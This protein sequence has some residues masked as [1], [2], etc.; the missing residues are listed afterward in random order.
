SIYT[1]ALC[2]G[3]T[4]EHRWRRALFILA[5]IGTLTFNWT[6]GAITFNLISIAIP[7]VSINYGGIYVPYSLILHFPLG[8]ILYWAKWRKET[9]IRDCK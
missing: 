1:A 5:G 8:L 6:T 4:P 3:T 2:F 7:N 9:E